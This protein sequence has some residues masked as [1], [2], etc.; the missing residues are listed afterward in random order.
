M[1]GFLD[2]VRCATCKQ[3]IIRDVYMYMDQPYCSEY[4]R[5]HAMNPKKKC[6]KWTWSCLNFT[7]IVE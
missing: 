4:H 2:T 5:S 1:E 3:E 7:S 6:E